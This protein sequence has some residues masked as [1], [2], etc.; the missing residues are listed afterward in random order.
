VVLLPGRHVA[1]R[2]SRVS[3]RTA[4]AIALG[5]GG[6]TIA[7]GAVFVVDEAPAENA[8]YD[9]T[10]QDLSAGSAYEAAG[11]GSPV[12]RD[13]EIR[14]DAAPRV[15]RSASRPVLASVQRAAKS[16]AMPPAE[17]DL[18]GA[19]TEQVAPTDPRDIAMGMLKTYG[20]S[21]D[22]FSCLNELYLHESNWDP[23]AQNPS[24]GAYGIPQALPGD[25]MA[26]YGADWQT[27]PATQLAWGLNYIK[28]RYG[29]PC[30]A[31]G[32]WQANNWY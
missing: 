12:V 27:D 15:S 17:Q 2:K 9:P 21:S 16:K 4:T 1:L 22:Q 19:V 28:D 20:W 6:A 26:A 13:E 14:R 31:W 24:S 11:D 18:S 25:K 5:V 23:S 32:F 8:A 3:R 7:V 29:S 10:S 30:G